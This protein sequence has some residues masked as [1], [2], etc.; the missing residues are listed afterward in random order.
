MDHTSFTI[1]DVV[2]ASWSHPVIADRKL[3]L[4]EQDALYCYDIADAAE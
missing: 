2:K 4:R 3:L 1:P